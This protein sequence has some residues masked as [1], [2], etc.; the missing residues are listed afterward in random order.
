V[1][2]FR[3]RP[4]APH[5]GGHTGRARPVWRTLA[6]AGLSLAVVSSNGPAWSSRAGSSRAGSSG[7]G[8]SP[9]GSAGAPVPAD[10]ASA[11]ADAVRAAG[12]EGRR[13]VLAAPWPLS[14]ADTDF[15]RMVILPDGFP[16]RR[17]RG[18]GVVHPLYG[19]YLVQGFLAGHPAYALIPRRDL[20]CPP[21]PVIAHGPE[22]VDAVLGP[23]QG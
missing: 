9:E 7:A 14:K 22:Q 10:P 21:S 17:E 16:A 18:R 15:Y 2:S 19:V 11:P 6:V 13:I 23:D 20:V 1:I 3:A 5:G 8:S 12:D 4:A